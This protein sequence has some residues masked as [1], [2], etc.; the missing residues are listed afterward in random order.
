MH[1]ADFIEFLKTFPEDYKI[2]LF[3]LRE[4][5]KWEKQDHLDLDV[6]GK[7]KAVNF[8]MYDDN[9]LKLEQEMEKTND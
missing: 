1:I 3:S 6:D 5:L 9:L 8:Y 7:E 4:S 2:N